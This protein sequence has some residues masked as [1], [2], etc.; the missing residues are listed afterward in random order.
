MSACLAEAITSR[1][2]QPALSTGIALVVLR[3]KD[4]RVVTGLSTIM[5]DI[6]NNYDSGSHRINAGGRPRPAESRSPLYRGHHK[7][8]AE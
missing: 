1:H 6:S 7:K 8:A 3:R 4:Y 2:L 5:F